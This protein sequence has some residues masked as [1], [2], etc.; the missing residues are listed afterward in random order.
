MFKHYC[1]PND[2]NG[3]PRRVYVL[4]DDG[5]NI[6]AWDEGYLGSDAVPGVF[7]D[8][9]YN[10]ERVNCSATMYRKLCKLPSPKWAHDIPGYE[11]LRTP[12]VT[13]PTY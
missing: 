10:A 1:A 9:A 2:V 6:A 5:D 7:R 11:H 13:Y 3:N 4:V 8:A 12:A